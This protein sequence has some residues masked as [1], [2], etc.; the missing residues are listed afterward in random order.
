MVR[1]LVI[2]LLLLGSGCPSGPARAQLTGVDGCGEWSTEPIPTRAGFPVIGINELDGD[3]ADEVWA[4]GTARE[5]PDGGS[6]SVPYLIRLV[7]GEWQSVDPPERAELTPRQIE[8]HGG[9]VWLGASY[10]DVSGFWRPVIFHRAY[11]A[12]SWTPLELGRS[13]DPLPEIGQDLAAET[14]SAGEQTPVSRRLGSMKVFAED[15]I[16]FT[17]SVGDDFGL[18]PAA[19]RWDGE[20]VDDFMLPAGNG[21]SDISVLD[22]DGVSTDDLW[23]VGSSSSQSITVISPYVVRWNGSDWST[24]GGVPGGSGGLAWYSGVYARMTD[25]VVLVGRDFDSGGIL[26]GLGARWDGAGFVNDPP[27]LPA[28]AITPLDS[29]GAVVT[30]GNLGGSSRAAQGAP[31]QSEPNPPDLD[32]AEGRIFEILATGPCALWAAVSWSIEQPPPVI[33]RLEASRIFSDG[34]ES[35][36]TSAWSLEVR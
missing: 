19:S 29:V 28:N 22:L 7:D 10:R 16:W 6:A 20:A 13:P 21:D 5:T 3:G 26:S 33:Y 18:L 24:V 23:V 36:D 12:A 31:W 4:V 2:A 8:F 11:G 9:R 25:D 27:V 1:R 15:D 17:V 34:F 32:G 14:G 30:W 35:G